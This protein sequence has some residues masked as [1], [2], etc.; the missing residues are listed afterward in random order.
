MTNY[1]R[2]EWIFEEC[3]KTVKF[4]DIMISICEDWIVT[5]LY[6]KLMNLYLYIPPYSA[7]PTGVFTGIVCGNILHIH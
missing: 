4:M 6:E 1:Y 2:L 5:S 7:H 3:S